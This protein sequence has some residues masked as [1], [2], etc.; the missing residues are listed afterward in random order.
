MFSN[1]QQQQTFN[2]QPQQFQ[3]AVQAPIIQQSNQMQAQMQAQMQTF[4]PQQQYV[5]APS[6]NVFGGSYGR[7]P[8]ARNAPVQPAIFN[9]DEALI[10]RVKEEKK[11][12]KIDI[13]IKA[14]RSMAKLK[15]EVMLPAMVSLKTDGGSRTSVDLICV[16]DVSGSMGG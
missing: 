3:Y 1:A 10:E 16:I 15:E 6:S 8:Q 4:A 12:A 11:D 13:E 7:R 9:D 2:V 14:Q 5:N